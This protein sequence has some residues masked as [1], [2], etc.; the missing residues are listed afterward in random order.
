MT[1]NTVSLQR[2]AQNT[3]GLKAKILN[4][5]FALGRVQPNRKVT[6]LLFNDRQ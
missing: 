1:L 5:V 3:I 6:C 4:A 2:L